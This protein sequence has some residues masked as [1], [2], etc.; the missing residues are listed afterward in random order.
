MFRWLLLTVSV[1]WLAFAAYQCAMTWP[2][3]SLDLSPND[4]ATIEA[5]R[6]AVISHVLVWALYGLVPVVAAW[7][8]VLAGKIKK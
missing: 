1:I 8:V 6:G 7:L 3:I 5:H 4:P 2:V